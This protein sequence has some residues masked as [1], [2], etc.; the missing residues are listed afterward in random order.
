MW[1]GV[2]AIG[3]NLALAWGLYLAAPILEIRLAGWPLAGQLAVIVLAGLLALLPLEILVG[4]AVEAMVE[5]TT[6]TLGEWLRDWTHGAVRFWVAA[7]LG[8]AALGFG[9]HWW[10]AAKLS[11]GMIVIIVCFVTAEQSFRAIP[12]SWRPTEPPDPAFVLGLRG[13]CE[14]L[15]IPPAHFT[16]IEDTDAFAVNGAIVSPILMS[17]KEQNGMVIPDVCL[18]TSVARYLQPRQAAFMVARELFCLK[19]GYRRISLFISLLW[20]AA[21]FVLAWGLPLGPSP[22]TSAL[23]GMAVM[24]T[25]CFVALFVWPTVCRRWVLKAD[26]YLLTLASA[27]EVADLLVALQ[28]LNATDTEL[29]PSKEAIF[30]PI[31]TLEQRLRAIGIEFH[32]PNPETAVSN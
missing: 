1:A 18:S 10:L 3:L 16:W 28:E 23:G 25:W 30:H 9:A 4:H 19:S 27:E 8:G 6:Q 14:E 5:R 13:E 32:E 11:L 20:L 31:P 15:R 21:G 2:T 22:L 24:T 7:S 29:S 17:T 26:A 12:A